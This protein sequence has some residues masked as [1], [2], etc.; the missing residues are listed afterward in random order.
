ME[1]EQ[2]IIHDSVTLDMLRDRGCS[3]L[4]ENIRVEAPYRKHVFWLPR[5]NN[6]QG[7]V[8]RIQARITLVGECN[9]VTDCG[10]GGNFFVGELLTTAQGYFQIDKPDNL[11]RNWFRS[12]CGDNI[13]SY[14]LIL[15]DRLIAYSS[16]RPIVIHAHESIDIHHTVEVRPVAPGN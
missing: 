3:E 2:Y 9:L 7:L 14:E 8:V 6:T 15:R 5:R 13:K 12:S 10:M 11:N 16:S 4:P 1:N